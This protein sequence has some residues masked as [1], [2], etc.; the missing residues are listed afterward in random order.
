MVH[1]WIERA[2]G[3]RPGVVFIGRV[4]SPLQRMLLRAS[5]GRVSL[6][7]RAAVLLLTTTGRRTGRPRTVPLF[8]LRDGEALVV[9]NVTPPGERTNPW[10]LNLRADPGATVE[11]DGERIACLAR[12][13]STTEIERLWPDLVETWPAY[14]RFFERGGRRS[15]FVLEPGGL[16][17]GRDGPAHE[18]G[19]GSEQ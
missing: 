15:V 5:G 2:G 14:R 10:T 11:V 18:G 3:S 16:S 12:E 9:C 4:V 1:G 7:G 8:Y 13:A 19:K 17:T 6:T